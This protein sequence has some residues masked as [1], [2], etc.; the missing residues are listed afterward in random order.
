MVTEQKG[1]F[2]FHACIFFLFFLILC[3]SQSFDLG[4]G[5]V[6]LS[7]F[8][9]IFEPGILLHILFAYNMSL[10]EHYWLGDIN[11]MCLE[12]DEPNVLN[13]VYYIKK[14]DF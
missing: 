3:Q 2:S 14:Y 12:E 1:R 11:L 5:V 7:P 4:G 8:Y 13:L 10:G 9:D 6:F